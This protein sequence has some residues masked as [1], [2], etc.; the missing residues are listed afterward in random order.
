MRDM[1]DSHVQP[2]QAAEGQSFPR[3]GIGGRAH[4]KVLVPDDHQQRFDRQACLSFFGRQ[5]AAR[6]LRCQHNHYRPQQTLPQFAQQLQDKFGYYITT[7]RLEN[8]A[9]EFRVSMR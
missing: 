4:R 6:G 3:H 9:A 7:Q 1:T 8:R 5:A 2:S